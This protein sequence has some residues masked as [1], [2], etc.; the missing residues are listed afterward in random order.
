[1]IPPDDFAG[2]DLEHPDGPHRALDTHLSL[3]EWSQPAG[4]LE[5]NY[6][7]L[8]ITAFVQSHGYT[9]DFS[10]YADQER[11]NLNEARTCFISRPMI[12]VALHFAGVEFTRRDRPEE[13]PEYLTRNGLDGYGKDV[14]YHE[15]WLD[16]NKV[17]ILRPEMLPHA[18]GFLVLEKPFP[19]ADYDANLVEEHGH[20]VLGSLDIEAIGWRTVDDISSAEGPIPGIVLYCY[21]RPNEQ[22]TRITKQHWGSAPPLVMIDFSG[23]PF[24]KEYEIGDWHHPRSDD[25][26]AQVRPHVASLRMFLCSVFGLMHAYI[27]RDRPSRPQMKKAKRLKM[28]EDGDVSVIQLRKFLQTIKRKTDAEDYDDEGNPNWSHRW[29]VRPHWA[30]RRCKCEGHGGRH[31]VYIEGY[32][33]GPEYLPL[34]IK[35]KVYAVVR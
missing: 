31:R 22:H 14:E 30:W 5:E 3:W 26:G 19:Y 7:M 4:R 2:F 10:L 27:E 35:E 24:N 29:L 34:V 13:T 9:Q 17:P 21:V 28:P 23:F 18:N 12:D 8:F 1:M 6:R 16:E 25:H 11:K 32:I 33:K 15:L 20:E